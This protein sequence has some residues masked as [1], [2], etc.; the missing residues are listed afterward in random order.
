MT[1]MKDMNLSDLQ[2]I[3]NEVLPM[4][5]TSMTNSE[6]TQTLLTLLP[7]LPELTIEKGG[8]CPA[9]Y[10]G[11]MVEIYGDGFY[12]SVLRFDETETKKAMRAIT[13]GEEP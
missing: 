1:K 13:E 2:K 9:S 6:I 11:D 10:K 4:I 5:T 7:M 8:T 12:H 3:A